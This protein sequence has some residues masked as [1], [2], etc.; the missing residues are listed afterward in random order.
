[1]LPTGKIP[2]EKLKSIVFRRLGIEDSRVLIKPGVGV[3]ATAID[4]GDTIL[5]ASTDPITGASKHIGFYAINVNANDVATFGAKPKWFLVTILLPEDA[6]EVLLEEIM[7]DLDKSARELGISIVG[8]HT[9]VTPGLNRPIVVGTMF[10]EVKR[11]KLIYSSNA[12]AGDA[13]ILTKGAAIEGTSIIAMEKEEELKEV[14][15]E[16]FV[17][18]AKDFLWKISVVKDALIAGEIG[19]SAM[20]DP[21][22]GGIT[23]GLH[24]MADAGNL[25]FRV[26]W[27]RIPIAEETKKI[28]EYYNL[29]P[30]ALI[31]SGALMISAPEENAGKIVKALKNENIEASV[32]GEFLKDRNV[33]VIIRDGKEEKLKQPSSDE[34]WK[35]F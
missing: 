23:N 17:R 10:G 27:E 2:P 18:R 6:D 20:H 28:C 32:I 22:E 8:G 3:D 1:M 15:G 11:E 16:E 29:D 30:L 14:F 13:I 34:L 24:E 33:R 5:V 21:T 35:L 9:E 31:S 12:R 4:L 7:D 26:Y 25:G 19:V